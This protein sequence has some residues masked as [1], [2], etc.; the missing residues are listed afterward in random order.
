MSELKILIEHNST[1]NDTGFQGFVDGDP[2]NS[3]MIQDPNDQ[4]ILKVNAEGTLEGFGITEVF[5][6]TSEPEASDMSLQDVLAR[7]P[8]G[9]YRVTGQMVG[10]ETSTITA[11]FTH[12]IPAGPVFTSPEDEAEG[13]EPTATTI[14]WESVTQDL[15]GNA[16][17]IVGYQI[18]VE[19]DDDNSNP[20][21]FAQSVFS[22][23]LPSNSNSITIPSEF[24]QNN[25]CYKAEILAIEASGNQSISEREFTTGN[26]CE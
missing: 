23:Y 20:Q 17:N 5:Y 26:G 13:L 1:D 12:T 19:V 4:T 3:I 22:I 14:A 2:W 6:E 7:M 11:P 15:N 21:G 24:M 16:V 9:T 8:E 18:I 10:G 25:Q